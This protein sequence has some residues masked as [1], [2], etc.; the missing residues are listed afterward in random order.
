MTLPSSSDEAATRAV[1]SLH[2]PVFPSFSLDETTTTATQWV[3]YK[4]R[5]EN[6]LIA[7]NVTND[8]QKLALLLNYVVEE[9]YDIYDNLLIPGTEESHS[10]AIR[11]F[12]GHFKPKS[13]ISYEI[14][15]FSRIKQNANE[16]ISKFLYVSNNKQ[17]NMILEK[18]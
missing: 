18:T 1:S 14:Y 10:N 4:K 7:L 15:T 2:I 9:C 17:L 5:F 12:D 16:T 8:S 6:L 11:L 13:N 3:K